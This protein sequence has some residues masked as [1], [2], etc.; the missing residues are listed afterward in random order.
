MVRTHR[1][2]KDRHESLG[3]YYTYIYIYIRHMQ[4]S[5]YRQLLHFELCTFL[6]FALVSA[7]VIGSSREGMEEAWHIYIYIYM[8]DSAG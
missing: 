4:T 2:T 7:N 8:Y 6:H 1:K 5:V 3:L